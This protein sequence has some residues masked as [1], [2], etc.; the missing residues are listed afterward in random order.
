[1]VCTSRAARLLCSCACPCAIVVP[2][3]CVRYAELRLCVHNHSQQN[4]LIQ[5]VSGRC[6]ECWACPRRIAPVSDCTWIGGGVAG[7]VQYYASANSTSMDICVAHSALSARELPF[8]VT[9]K[10]QVC[11]FHLE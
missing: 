6:R 9:W 3:K 8:V 10:W 1:M 4:W 2:R 5:W 7:I 11:Q